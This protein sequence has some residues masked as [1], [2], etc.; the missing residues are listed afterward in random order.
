MTL[1]EIKEHIIN[2][3]DTDDVCEALHITTEDLLNAFEPQLVQY[4][5]AFEEDA[6]INLHEYTNK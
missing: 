5:H 1:E 3:Y 2:K 4:M 6:R